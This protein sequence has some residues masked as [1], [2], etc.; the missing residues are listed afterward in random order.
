MCFN[1]I[2]PIKRLYILRRFTIKAFGI[3]NIF[4]YKIS[5]SLT[6]SL[7]TIL[8]PIDTHIIFK[9]RLFFIITSRK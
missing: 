2:V 9:A 4:C 1:I 5:R 7:P 8:I 6:H 3:L